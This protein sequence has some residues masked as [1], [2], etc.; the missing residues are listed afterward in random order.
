MKKQGRIKSV[1]TL[2][3]TSVLEAVS[4]QRRHHPPLYP[5][6]RKPV[7]I[8]QEAR[9]TSGTFWTDTENHSLATVRTLDCPISSELFYR[10]R[11]TGHLN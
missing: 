6:V 4:G 7:P 10:L 8:V 2:Y 11:H 5:P 3:L 9:S 1:T